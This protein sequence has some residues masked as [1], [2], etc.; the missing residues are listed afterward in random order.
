M[1]IKKEKGAVLLEFSFALPILVLLAFLGYNL[2]SMIDVHMVKRDLSRTL[3]LSY[4]CS[5]R[6]GL[7][8]QTCFNDVVSS[9]DQTFSRKFKKI[10][11]GV[12]TY[13]LS[14][15]PNAQNNISN[16]RNNNC[17]DIDFPLEVVSN[18]SSPGFVSNF[19]PPPGQ[20][21]SS[22]VLFPNT[23]NNP[24]DPDYQ[25]ARQQLC[26]NGR[27]TISEIRVTQPLLFNFTG[28]AIRDQEYYEY[29]F[30]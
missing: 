26:M 8:S 27:I 2:M 25:K 13:R 10:E 12:Q 19:T 5:F 22:Y 4:L 24:N 7:V 29:G 11:Y 1:N 9:L 21:I 6:T 17:N 23:H 16:Q 3:S 15:D 18:F 20:T 14:Q 30:I 28:S